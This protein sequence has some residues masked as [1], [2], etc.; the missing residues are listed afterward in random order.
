MYSAGYTIDQVPANW[1]L[2]GS[3]TGICSCGNGLFFI[4]VVC[5][6][7]YMMMKKGHFWP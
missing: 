2:M 7:D 1:K 4:V 5:I 6:E 3:D